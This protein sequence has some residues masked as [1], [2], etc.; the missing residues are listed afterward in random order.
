MG[1]FYSI[2]TQ[3]SW[4]HAVQVFAEGKIKIHITNWVGVTV[5]VF[6]HVQDFLSLHA[7]TGTVFTEAMTA[8][9]QS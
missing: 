5:S 8:P 2:Y 7:N 3:S 1:Q 6:T 9:S 4:I